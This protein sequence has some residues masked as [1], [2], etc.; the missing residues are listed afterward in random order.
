MNSKWLVAVFLVATFAAATPGGQARPRMVSGADAQQRVNNLT[1]EMR[2]Y[3][4]LDQAKAVARS[5]DKMVF[6]VHM[7]GDLSG[8]T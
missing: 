6:W 4:S 7:L 8:A 5:Q 3:K 2:W 1:N